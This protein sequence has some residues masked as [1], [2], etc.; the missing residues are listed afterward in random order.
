M[1]KFLIFVL[2]LIVA[3]LVI[4]F[5]PNI[6]TQFGGLSSGDNV[7]SGGIT[8][9]TTSISNYPATNLILARNTARQYALICNETVSTLRVQLSTA[10]NPNQEVGIPLYASSTGRGMNCY[11]IDSSNLYLGAIYGIASATSVVS[12]TEK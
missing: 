10:V 2:V 3:V 12:I 11:E 1:N 4:E 5:V 7:F 9:S 6:K 8:M